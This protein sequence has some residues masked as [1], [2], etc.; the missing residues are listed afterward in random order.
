MLA[1]ILIYLLCQSALSIDK[2]SVALSGRKVISISGWHGQ[3]V[4]LKTAKRRVI[5]VK[6]CGKNKCRS[7]NK[8]K[9]TTEQTQLTTTSR[10][11]MQP[12]K[13]D[14]TE[15]QETSTED[16]TSTATDVETTVQLMT[17]A[18]TSPPETTQLLE[19]TTTSHYNFN[20]HLNKHFHK[21][22]HKYFHKHFNKY[23]NKHFNKYFNKYFNKHFNKY[24]NKHFNINHDNYNN[25][26]CPAIN[27]TVNINQQNEV[28]NFNAVNKYGVLLSVGWVIILCNKKYVHSETT[29]TLA[30][31]YLKCCQWGMK[32]ASF[33][34]E[35]DASCARTQF[36]SEWTWVAATIDGSPSNPR[37]CTA[38][39]SYLLKDFTSTYPTL[40]GPD[41]DTIAMS[42]GSI[43]FTTKFRDNCSYGNQLGAHD[44]FQLNFNHYNH[45]Y[46]FN[47]FNINHDNYNYHSVTQYGVA[48]SFGYVIILCNKKYVHSFTTRTDSEWSWVAT[49]IDGNPSNPRWC[50]ADSSYL[51]KD[52]TSAFPTLPGPEF[53]AIAMD[54]GHTTFTYIQ[55]NSTM[56]WFLCVE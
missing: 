43:A 32:L 20:I 11:S 3:T 18:E 46:N 50:T 26:L 48:L 31:A 13:T 47:H 53:D 21:Y 4:Y 35:S 38:D 14:F 25:H 41:Y 22:F 56:T 2:G 24:F 45:V 23:F 51:L 39:S 6:C 12:Q 33:A 27:C 17:S 29:V 40:P 15:L 5:I 55:S 36:N 28:K 30:D 49:S 37:W 44:V 52:F 10:S 19:P 42:I 8:T 54:I 1:L 9:N 7:T 34:N 16:A